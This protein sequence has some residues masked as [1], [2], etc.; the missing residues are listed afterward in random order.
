[1]FRIQPRYAAIPT[2]DISRFCRQ[3][4]C[5]ISSPFRA[6]PRCF[7]A[8]DTEL[9]LEDLCAKGFSMADRKAG[10]DAQHCYAAMRE[11]A[12][13]HALSLAMKLCRPQEFATRV[14]ACVQEALFVPENEEWYRGYYRAATRNALTMVSIHLRPQCCINSIFLCGGGIEYLHG[15]PVSCKR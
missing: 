4:T 6:A 2:R 11:L 8:R 12:L 15:S 9:V 1:L 10:L 13:L 14:A 7:L 5:A 3:E